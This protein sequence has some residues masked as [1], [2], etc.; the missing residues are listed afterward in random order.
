MGT[1]WQMTRDDG[2]GD[3]DGLGHQPE[4]R[5]VVTVTCLGAAQPD[6][7]DHLRKAGLATAARKFGDSISI[8]VAS[9]REHCT[10]KLWVN[11]RLSYWDFEKATIYLG[12][13]VCRL[14]H[15]GGLCN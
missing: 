11:S 6:G 2:E 4:S 1:T 10:K 3:G 8:M 15:G 12:T 13:I 14:S 7:Q 9:R 5:A